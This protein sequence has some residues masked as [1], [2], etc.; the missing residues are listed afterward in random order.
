MPTAADGFIRQVLNSGDKCL[1]MGDKACRC[2]LSLGRFS[3]LLI[4][5][6]LT[7]PER[8]LRGE[9][10]RLFSPDEYFPPRFISD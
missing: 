2:C 1:P 7:Q 4:S 9:A 6:S 5:P 3:V 8:L 10:I